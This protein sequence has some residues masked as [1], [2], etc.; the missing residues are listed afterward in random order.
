MNNNVL[1][2]I[3]FEQIMGING[4]GSWWQ[5]ALGFGGIVVGSLGAAA[6]VGAGAL[7]I[8]TLNPA[9][10]YGAIMGAAGSVAAIRDSA[11]YLDKNF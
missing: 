4:G 7:A 2:E 1:C 9:L 3:S 8:A 5:F 11:S 6:S 10:G